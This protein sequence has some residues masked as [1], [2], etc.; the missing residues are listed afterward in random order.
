MFKYFI[1]LIFEF[2]I[3]NIEVNISYDIIENYRYIYGFFLVYFFK[4]IYFS[5]LFCIDYML[6]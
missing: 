5:I 3:F 2:I 6:S 4:F 1:L